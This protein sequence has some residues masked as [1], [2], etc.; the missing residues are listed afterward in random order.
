M[1]TFYVARYGKL[2]CLNAGCYDILSLLARTL[3]GRAERIVSRFLSTPI[4][5]ANKRAAFIPIV[6]SDHFNH[7]PRRLARPRTPPF[8]GGNTGSNPVGDANILKDLAMSSHSPEGSIS[9]HPPSSAHLLGGFIILK[10]LLCTSRFAAPG[11][12][13]DA[14]KLTL[15]RRLMGEGLVTA[16]QALMARP[17]SSENQACSRPPCGGNDPLPARGNGLGFPT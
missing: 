9:T 11:N 2:T 4:S 8:H 12:L 5:F 6:L 17:R 10:T 3:P 7:R 13:D 14:G 15:V 16:L 1:V